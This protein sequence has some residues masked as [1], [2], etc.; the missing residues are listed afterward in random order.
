MK[1]CT[2]L[3]TTQKQ[4]NQNPEELSS[5]Q[6]Q[7]KD[8]VWNSLLHMYQQG[9]NGGQVDDYQTTKQEKRQETANNQ[10]IKT[11]VSIISAPSSY[12]TKMH[13]ETD[14]VRSKTVK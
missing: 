14:T 1:N 5:T 10:A 11:I 12:F 4:T 8:E 6:K 3:K 13:K 2:E 7:K 9:E